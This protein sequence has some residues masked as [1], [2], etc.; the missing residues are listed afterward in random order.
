MNGQYDY[1]LTF[2]ADDMP[3]VGAFWS[4]TAYG[5]DGFL[6]YNENAATLGIERYALSTNTPLERDENGDI[7]LYISSQPPQGVPLSNW[8]PVPSEDFQLTLR[9]YDPGE[10]ILSGTWKVPDVV[11]AN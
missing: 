5:D 8:L 1:T 9:F 11:R 6:K 4:I 10:E 2:K 3:D 7:T